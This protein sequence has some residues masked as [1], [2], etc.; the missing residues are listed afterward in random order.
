MSPIFKSQLEELERLVP[1]LK[2]ASAVEHYDESSPHMHVVGIPVAT[3][4]KKGL[5]K[6]VAKTKIFTPDR[7]SFLQDKMRV[8]A[9]KDVRSCNSMIF[10]TYDDSWYIDL[11]EKKPGR[12]RDIPKNSLD[13]YYRVKKETEKKK[14]KG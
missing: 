4:Y 2:I 5:S 6:Q 12:N 7:L 14:K 9:N 1:E 13:E 11:D 10:E 3:G 8:S